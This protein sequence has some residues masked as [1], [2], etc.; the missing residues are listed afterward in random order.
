MS[1]DTIGDFLTVVRNGLMVS[2]RSVETPYSKI[3][4]EIVK[5]LKDEGFIK[6]FVFTEEDSKKMIKLFL[7][8][9]SGESV[10]HEIT[11]ISTPGRRVYGKSDQ[12]K[13]V[14]G[15]L[16]ISILTTNKGIMTDKRAKDLS[17]GGE[18]IC[19]VW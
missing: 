15:K 1:I 6:D 19:S 4:V 17:V 14:I 2:K 18:I 5:I 13:N 16:G 3:K 7:K 11:R 9:A 12:I 10:I 8:Y